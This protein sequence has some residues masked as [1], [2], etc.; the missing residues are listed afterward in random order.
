MEPELDFLHVQA[1]NIA[2]AQNQ[3][4]R[5]RGLC[6]GGWMNFENFVFG[7]PG[8]EAGARAA[9]AQVLGEG[10]ADFFFERMM[11]YFLTEQDLA[12]I[13]KLGC[14]LVR[15]PL[16]YRHF[17][18]DRRPFEYKPEGFR[19]LDN[20]IAWAR[21]HS[22][23]VILDLHAAAGCQN[24]GWHSDNGCR[25]AHFWE[26]K[27]FQDRA[28]ALWEEIARRYRGES[29]VAGY[30]LINEP[31]ADQV[32]QL[33]EF[34]RRTTAAIRAIDSQHILFLEG[35]SFSQ[36]FDQ[37]D[38]PFDTNTVYSS[39]NYV[40]PALERGQYPGE[41]FGLM[42]DRAR[43]E[44]EYLERADFMIRHRVPN[45]IG[46]FGALFGGSEFDE[47]RLRVLSDLISIFEQYG[48]NWTL[49]TYKDI[50]W[51]GLVHLDPES[52]WMERTRPVRD[53]KS[54][55]RCDYWIERGEGRLDRCL[56]ELVAQ[57]RTVVGHLPVD[58]AQMAARLN[59]ALYQGVFS[60]TLLPAFAEQFRG[61][62]ENEID[63][64][65]QSFQF[66]SCIPRQSLVSLIAG[67]AKR[68]VPGHVSE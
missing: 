53:A 9:V 41:F 30:N 10:R 24:P 33:N 39:H 47:S 35:D 34:Y 32:G 43:L 58:W 28:L 54:A 51:M 14:N 20:L 3:V 5:L 52:E 36:Q 1:E 31:M 48:H 63:R 2:N 61:M 66:R 19:R 27:E 50:G 16:N 25:T 64:M 65:M 17:E 49:W 6:V 15:L 22:I 38:P 40:V 26:Q 13:S 7:Y 62:T 21:A 23:Y 68:P 11:D 12:F 60:Q 46:E 42:Y 55:L 57:T 8:H 45:W 18:L 29:V 44:K 37:L 4:V 67:L 56:E 59:D